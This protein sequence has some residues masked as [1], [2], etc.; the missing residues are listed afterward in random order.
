MQSTVLPLFVSFPNFRLGFEGFELFEKPQRMR[1]RKGPGEGPASKYVVFAYL[2]GCG[3]HAFV[4]CIV[5]SVSSA[6]HELHTYLWRPVRLPP[7]LC[8]FMSDL[9]WKIGDSRPAQDL[10]DPNQTESHSI[11]FGRGGWA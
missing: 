10:I 5:V 11:S 8:K 7:R 2:I 3:V 4:F 9:F 6:V 1:V